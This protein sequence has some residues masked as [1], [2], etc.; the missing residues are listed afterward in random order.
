MVE[1]AVM[2]IMMA[3]EKQGGKDT[4]WPCAAKIPLVDLQSEQESDSIIDARKSGEEQR[5]IR[6]VGMSTRIMQRE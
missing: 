1:N 2:L 4:G 3:K 6:S 5:N